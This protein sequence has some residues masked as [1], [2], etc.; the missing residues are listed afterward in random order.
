MIK[1]IYSQWRV[2]G[3]HPYHHNRIAQTQ[4]DFGGPVG[5]G[6]RDGCCCCAREGRKGFMPPR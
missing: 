1:Q 5:D 6:G 4:A 3:E 2:K